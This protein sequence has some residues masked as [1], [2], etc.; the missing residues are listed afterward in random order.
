MLELALSVI[1]LKTI[2]GPCRTLFAVSPMQ[3]NEAKCEKHKP[4]SRFSLATKQADIDIGYVEKERVFQ[5]SLIQEVAN[6]IANIKYILP[7]FNYGMLDVIEK[8][9]SHHHLSCDDYFDVY[10]NLKSVIDIVSKVIDLFAQLVEKIPI[11]SKELEK[12]KKDIYGIQTRLF[13]MIMQFYASDKILKKPIFS[14]LLQAVL[15][16][17]FKERIKIHGLI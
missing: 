6:R 2:N 5:K 10:C 15:D 11:T 13:H 3:W 7:I 9:I 12:M 16:E 14:H 17:Y 1:I 8:I 4:I